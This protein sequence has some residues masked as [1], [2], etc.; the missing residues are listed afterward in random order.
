[1]AFRQPGAG[2]LRHRV[3][4]QTSATAPAPGGGSSTTWTD[5]HTAWAQV[6][7]LTG[8]ERIQAMQTD[9]TLTHRI[10]VRHNA[11]INPGM[12]AVIGGK[13]Y[14]IAPPVDPEGRRR[15]LVMLVEEVG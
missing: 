11:G 1:M 13:V 4:F 14:N 2:D 15:W 3:L 12:R 6:E 10:T 5:W 7:G 9:S 8:V